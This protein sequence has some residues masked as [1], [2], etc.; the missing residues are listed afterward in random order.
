[1]VRFMTQCSYFTFSVTT[2]AKSMK[3]FNNPK[4]LHPWPRR[5][6][7]LQFSL[8]GAKLDRSLY[9]AKH[10]AC[11][12]IWRVFGK[13]TVIDR[14][15]FKATYYTLF[16]SDFRTRWYVSFEKHQVT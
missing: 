2:K 15:D 6:M 5:P 3:D 9:L 8:I 1:M 4:F 13:K 16:G 10:Y 14:A 12:L 11:A 7:K